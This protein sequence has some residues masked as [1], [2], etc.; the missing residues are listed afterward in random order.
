MKSITKMIAPLWWVITTGLLFT[1]QSWDELRNAICRHYGHI[2]YSTVEA[3]KDGVQ[4]KYTREP[5]LNTISAVRYSFGRAL[6]NRKDVD[7]MLAYIRHVYVWVHLPKQFHKLIGLTVQHIHRYVKQ[8]PQR[9]NGKPK[10]MWVTES[11]YRKSPLRKILYTAVMNKQYNVWIN[12]SYKIKYKTM[13]EYTKSIQAF[14][15]FKGTVWFNN[16]IAYSVFD[17]IEAR[18]IAYIERESDVS[19]IKNAKICI[20]SN[21]LKVK[22]KL[23][24]NDGRYV[25][26]WRLSEFYENNPKGFLYAVHE[27]NGVCE[28]RLLSPEDKEYK[29]PDTQYEGVYTFDPEILEAEKQ[30]IIK[31]A[32][33]IAKETWF[34]NQSIDRIQA[35]RSMGYYKWEDL[36]PKVYETHPWLR[37]EEEDN[38]ETT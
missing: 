9:P 32:H 3:V 29:R 20:L 21:L 2:L 5:W 19:N 1:A 24:S 35:L 25:T 31:A 22:G 4:T 33:D 37:P 11:W 23:I 6:Y 30:A 15:E 13:E 7:G 36:L 26:Q 34:S 16:K 28:L 18:D 17:I 27:D 8:L 12:V 38:N 10:F 14:N